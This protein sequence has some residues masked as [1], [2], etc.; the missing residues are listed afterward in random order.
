MYGDSQRQALS[1]DDSAFFKE[2]VLPKLIA[3]LDSV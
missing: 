1:R 3:E 2:A